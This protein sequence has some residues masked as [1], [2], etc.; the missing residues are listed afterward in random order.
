[1]LRGRKNGGVAGR[2]T[3]SRTGEFFIIRLGRYEDFSKM[4]VRL[5]VVVF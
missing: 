2:A 3:S 4:S 5:R 1:M